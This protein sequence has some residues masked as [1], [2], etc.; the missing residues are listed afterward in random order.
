MANYNSLKNAAIIAPTTTPDLGSATN[1]YGNVFL[2]GNVDIGGTSLTSTNAIAPRIATLTYIGDD[3]AAGVAGGETITIN[4][5]GFN[6]GAS[7]YI[8]GTIVSVVSV[9][10]STQITFT[11]PAKS[12]GNYALIVVNPD[13]AS[14][15][16]VPGMQYSGVP[17]WSTAAGSLGAFDGS[18]SFSISLSA[19]SD[20]A[21]TYNIASGA[22]PSG[23]TLNS[24]TGGLSGTLPTVTVSTTYNF[25]VRATDGENQS[26]DRNFSV[27]VNV[28]SPPGQQAY[29]TAGTYSWTA[30]AGVTTVSVVCVGGGGSGGSQVFPKTGGGGGGLG[31][32]NAISVVPGQSYTVVVGVGGPNGSSGPG[33]NS[34]FINLSTVAGLGGAGGDTGGAGGSFAGDGGAS[35]GNGG[36]PILSTNFSGGGGGAGGY[37]T[38]TVATSG[39]GGTDGTNTGVAG[40]FGGGGGGGASTRTGAPTGFSGPGGGVGIFGEGSSGAGGITVPYGTGTG[41][42]AGSGGDGTLYGGGGQTRIGGSETEPGGRG[43]VRIIW[44][45]GRAFPST[46]TTNQ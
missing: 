30:P 22:L 5:S 24:S 23:I 34:Y 17:S 16:F 36:V 42:T 3:T 46:L 9:V 13:G 26:T 6:Y 21:V 43:A 27:N 29:T 44:G 2:S 7:L 45:A 39:N 35:G 14:A 28:P 8:G 37:R 31:W 18:S 15:T 4:G 12:A 41:G 19:T 10:S 40:E 11:S 38:R 1:R 33:G 20:S 25:T 32:K